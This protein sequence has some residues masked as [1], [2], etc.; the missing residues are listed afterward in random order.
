MPEKFHYIDRKPEPMLKM[1]ASQPGVLKERPQI[2]SFFEVK[3]AEIAFYEPE[4]GKGGR[5]IEI[6]S[7][8]DPQTLTILN[9]RIQREPDLASQHAMWDSLN[10]A[11]PKVK[12][13]TETGIEFMFEDEAVGGFNKKGGF[14]HNRKFLKENPDIACEVIKP[15]SSRYEDVEYGLRLARKQQT[16]MGTAEGAKLLVRQEVRFRTSISDIHELLD[17]I[18]ICL[19]ENRPVEDLLHLVSTELVIDPLGAWNSDD[20]GGH[21]KVMS[22]SDSPDDSGDSQQS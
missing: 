15:R 13:D 9:Q 2:S 12:I 6:G 22:G 17:L 7:V 4:S 16:S 14:W 20:E 8:M 19:E 18:G 21:G 11:L 10:L 1:P 3:P 5:V